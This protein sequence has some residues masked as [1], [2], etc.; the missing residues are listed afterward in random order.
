MRCPFFYG[1]ISSKSVFS[2]T[3]V[4]QH[5]VVHSEVYHWFI[6]EVD[7]MLFLK[8]IA[9][10]ILLIPATV[11]AEEHS[12]HRL[13]LVAGP[14]YGVGLSY[15]RQNDSTGIGWQI[16]GFPLWLEEERFLSGGF[17]L[18]KTLH[19][20]GGEGALQLFLSGG[21]AAYYSSYD[22][23]DSFWN[24]DRDIDESLTLVFG[25]GVGL[26]L[27]M[28]PFDFSAGLPVAVF[29]RN[30]ESEDRGRY[31]IIPYIPNLACFY[32]W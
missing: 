26:R 6:K 30:E 16:S 15:G 2:L 23:S 29:L 20:G 4:S 8:L 11:L 14:T 32:R 18:S 17:T 31:E 19:K 3:P 27:R 28:G 24:D 25:P 13:G 7:A 22:N 10:T 9:M 5:I 12:S 1:C 21:L